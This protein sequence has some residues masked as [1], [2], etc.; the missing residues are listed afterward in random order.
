MNLQGIA[1]NIGAINPAQDKS[2]EAVLKKYRTEQTQYDI[3]VRLN[4]MEHAIKEKVE[5]EL[6]KYNVETAKGNKQTSIRNYFES[7]QLTKFYVEQHKDIIQSVHEM[8]ASMLNV[9][10]KRT[11]KFL[12]NIT[13]SDIQEKEFL[14]E[15]YHKSIQF[16]EKQYEQKNKWSTKLANT[17]GTMAEQYLDYQG[18]YQ[19]AFEN[20]PIMMGLY[21]VASNS[22]KSY[23]ERER[24]RKVLE[25][26]DANRQL[27]G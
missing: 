17:L 25:A 6:H 12:D 23:R 8:D 10:L 19:A 14:I 5:E 9:Q 27:M 3:S 21:T 18:F 22:I 24:E 11:K 2:L 4:D 7:D 16:L 1:N 13:K 26:R 15:E 20:N